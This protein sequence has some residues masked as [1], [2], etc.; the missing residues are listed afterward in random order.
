MKVNKLYVF[1]ALL[2]LLFSIPSKS[3][4]NMVT[5]GCVGGDP[6][7][8]FSR[9]SDA[10]AALP[11]N[12]PNVIEVTGTCTENFWIW[13]SG[14]LAIQAP[15]GQTATIVSA[16]D[17]STWGGV[18]NIGGGGS[19]G[20][21]LYGLVLQGGNIGLH[22]EASSHVD[23]ENC[24]FQGNFADGLDVTDGSVVRF[25][26]GASKNNGGS[27]I[28]V[29]V[30]GTVNLN[31]FNG[32]NIELSNNA[33]NGIYANGATVNLNGRTTIA[34]NSGWGIRAVGATK[35]QVGGM[36][37]Q[38]VIRGNLT[39]GASIGEGSEASFW[40]PNLIQSN[41]PMGVSVSQHGQ[42]TFWGLSGWS[43]TVEGHTG[44][45]ISVSAHSQVW[46]SG[47][48]I[49]NNATGIG[50]GQAGI[51]VDGNSQLLLDSSEVTNNGGPGILV[52]INS[53]IDI[54]NSRLTGNSGEGVRLLHMSVADWGT[55]VNAL[56]NLGGV[57]TCDR[58]SLMVVDFQPPAT[59]VPGG[60]RCL[61]ISGSNGRRIPRLNVPSFPKPGPAV[62]LYHT[63]RKRA[64]HN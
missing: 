23:I 48:E 32:G 31:P 42:A 1:A 14:S 4:A 24:V 21:Y 13:Q 50:L 6:S 9:I 61:N 26:S 22:V 52:D 44:P 51:F 28:N 29:S 10:L 62:D 46:S 11:Q 5:V 30:N 53:S 25:I 64:L 57:L 38:N 45:A 49:R 8:T 60:V 58:T 7:A 27:G 12:T 43:A 35:A 59:T 3:Y 56:G 19:D 41:G 17:P 20:V 47:S 15:Y 34:S 37:E 18:I 39:G 63:L 36:F 16:I 54:S 33:G 2:F 55:A 40:G